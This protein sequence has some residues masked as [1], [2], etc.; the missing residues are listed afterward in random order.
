MGR[1][2]EVHRKRTAR[3]RRR[4]DGPGDIPSPRTAADAYRVSDDQIHRARM[5]VARNCADPEDLR[6]LLDMLGLIAAEP[7]PAAARQGA[8][9]RKRARTPGAPV[10]REVPYAGPA[11]NGQPLV[12]GDGPAVQAPIV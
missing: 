7:R 10:R 6:R 12:G 3:G 11:P 9:Q 2:D 1:R 8:D 5:V 4:T